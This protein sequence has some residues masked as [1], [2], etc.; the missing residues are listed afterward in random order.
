MHREQLDN[1]VANPLI[2]GSNNTIPREL[3]TRIAAVI[4]QRS[5]C[6]T[7]SSTK[8]TWCSSGNHSRKRCASG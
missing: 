7:T 2:N 3:L 1:S 4:A 6:S 5:T 8:S